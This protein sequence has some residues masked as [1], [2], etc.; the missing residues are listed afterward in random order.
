MVTAFRAA[1][2]RTVRKPVIRLLVLFPSLF[3]YK[4]V[5][6]E[7]V[8]AV[9]ISSQADV[10]LCLINVFYTAYRQAK[11]EKQI[12]DSKEL[13]H[14]FKLDL[15]LRILNEL[16]PLRAQTHSWLLRMYKVERWCFGP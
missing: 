4:R 12:Q 16:W 11:H 8:A 3:S 10:F 9:R 6:T 13:K 5:F 15:P 2:I 7:L 1:K 14:L